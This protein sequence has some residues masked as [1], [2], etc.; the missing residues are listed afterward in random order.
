[1]FPATNMFYE[2]RRH[3]LQRETQRCNLKFLFHTFPW[4]LAISLVLAVSRGDMYIPLE[5]FHN[6]SRCN[7]KHQCVLL[8][9]GVI[10]QNEAIYNCKVDWK[11]YKISNVWCASVFFLYLKYCWYC[12]QVFWIKSSLVLHVCRLKQ[13]HICY[14]NNFSVSLDES[15]LSVKTNLSLA[16]DFQCVYVQTLT[17]PFQYTNILL[18]Q[19]FHCASRCMFRVVLVLEPALLSDCSPRKFFFRSTMYLVLS[20]STEQHLYT[21]KIS[22]QPEEA[23]TM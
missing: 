11:W 7:Q 6:V 19:P 3:T 1:M 2:S 20:V 12:L 23:T 14:W 21:T 5:L 17:R 16:T 9:F 4:L 13:L 18:F 15:H 10:G 8:D 22:P